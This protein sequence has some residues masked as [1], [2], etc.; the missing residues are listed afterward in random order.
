MEDYVIIATQTR[1]GTHPFVIFETSFPSGTV[2]RSTDVKHRFEVSRTE[3]DAGLD[4]YHN[5][6]VYKKIE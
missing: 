2:A 1:K 5:V 6:S 3:D 4:E